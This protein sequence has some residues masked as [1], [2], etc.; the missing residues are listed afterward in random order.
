ML[1]G[2]DVW[3]LSVMRHFIAQLYVTKYLGYWTF[4][5]LK[6]QSGTV[7]LCLWSHASEDQ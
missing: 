5:L 1:L 4:V 3:F 2:F 6:D 7:A